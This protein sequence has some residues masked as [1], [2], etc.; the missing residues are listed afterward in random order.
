[1][2]TMPQARYGSLQRVLQFVY[3]SKHRRVKR[4]GSGTPV[5]GVRVKSRLR[6]AGSHWVVVG[7]FGGAE[8]PPSLQNG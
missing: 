7:A 2:H 6:S 3:E 8:V 4:V 5:A 1:M